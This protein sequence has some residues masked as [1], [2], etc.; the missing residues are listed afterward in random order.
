MAPSF[1]LVVAILVLL[2]MMDCSQGAWSRLYCNNSATIEP[3]GLV[4]TNIDNLLKG[5]K[6]SSNVVIR[7]SQNMFCGKFD[8]SYIKAVIPENGDYPSPA[9]GLRSGLAKLLDKIK[10]RITDEPDLGGFAN[11]KLPLTE[12]Y[13]LYRVAQ[14]IQDLSSEVCGK[15]LDATKAEFEDSKP[16]IGK[17]GCKVFYS[18]CAFRYAFKPLLP[19]YANKYEKISDKALEKLMRYE[20]EQINELSS[21]KSM[22]VSSF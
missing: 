19:P 6:S 16:C 17:M 21:K 5:M 2:F 11:V 3:Y 4:S 18:S 9:S 1:H 13:T 12:T 14:C 15:C 20:A 10:A 8:A 7:Y 22:M